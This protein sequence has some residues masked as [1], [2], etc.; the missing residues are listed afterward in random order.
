MTA[1]PRC[2]RGFDTSLGLDAHRRRSAACRYAPAERT[3]GY[4]PGLLSL[5]GRQARPRW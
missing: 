4:R 5:P 1:C 3:A 2:G